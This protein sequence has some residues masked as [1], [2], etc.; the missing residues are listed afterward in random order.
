MVKRAYLVE[1]DY[2]QNYMWLVCREGLGTNTIG[3]VN[4]TVKRKQLAE[5]A[6]VSKGLVLNRI[7]ATGE[8]G[9]CRAGLWVGAY[10]GYQT[11]GVAEPGWMTERGPQEKLLKSYGLVEGS[12]LRDV[13]MHE[14]L[15]GVRMVALFGDARYG[16]MNWAYESARFR[17]IPAYIFPVDLEMFPVAEAGGVLR[18]LLL[19]HQVRRLL[20]FGHSEKRCPGIFDY[21]KHV[22]LNA[23]DQ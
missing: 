22:L 6:L 11:G 7:M 17:G 14:T 10:L 18:S 19:S 3:G 20:V 9:A 8:T 23:L 21:T 5:N 13:R 12:K 16:G 15:R 4:V 1:T 2:P